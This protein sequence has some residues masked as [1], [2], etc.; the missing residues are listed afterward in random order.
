MCKGVEE[1][2]GSV[3]SQAATTTNNVVAPRAG[4]EE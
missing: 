4:C 2:E 3:S 1:A